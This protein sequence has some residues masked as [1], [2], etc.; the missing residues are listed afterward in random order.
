MTEILSVVSLVFAIIALLVS[1]AVA[2][3]VIGWKNSTHK[4][5]TKFVQADGKPL[6]MNKQMEEY[7]KDLELD[8]L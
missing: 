4:V 7:T 2:T 6:D 8:E 1:L 3:V 5:Y